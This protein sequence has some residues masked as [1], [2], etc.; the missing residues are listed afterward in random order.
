VIFYIL[1]I[2]QEDVETQG[3]FFRVLNR[4]KRWQ[5]CIDWNCSTWRSFNQCSL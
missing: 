5:Q 4:E 2:L 1:N 3:V